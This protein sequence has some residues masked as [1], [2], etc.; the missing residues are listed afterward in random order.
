VLFASAG[1]G[2]N[3]AADEITLWTSATGERRMTFAAFKGIAAS[4]AFSPDGKML[5]VGTID[6]RISL[7]ESDTGAERSSFVGTAGEVSSLAF[8]FDGKVL[9][10][11]V[12]LTGED[13]IVEVCRWDVERAVGRSTFRPGARS[14][15]AISPDGLTLAW[16][17]PGS[18][19]GL[20]AANVET[21]EQR[22]LTNVAIVR[23]DT[24][25]FSPD[26]K[27]IAA[28]HHADW[29]PFPNHCPYVYVI[30]A[31]TGR[32][33]VRSPRPFDERRGLA[34]SHDGKLLARGI[35]GGF[36]LWDLKAM[37]DRT[38]VSGPSSKMD[39]AELLVFSPDDLTLVSSDRRGNLLLWDVAKLAP[40]GG[41]VPAPR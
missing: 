5:A 15:F 36:E 27:Q 26:A 14:P 28:V 39:G 3:P 37:E 32:I 22:L 38:T 31:R 23:G 10:S 18:P 21:Q 25:V 7:L 1:G 29:S 40:I 34:I 12:H 33:L 24:L 9:V 13:E 2:A 20:W 6:G 16:I 11:V 19:S 41:A 8:T 4:L 17:V 30:D 35:D